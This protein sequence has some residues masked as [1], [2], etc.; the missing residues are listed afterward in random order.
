MAQRRA[1][2]H[3]QSTRVV[4]GTI[5]SFSPHTGCG[6]AVCDA[7]RLRGRVERESIA[8][9]ASGFRR[10]DGTPGQYLLT[11]VKEAC[12]L[13]GGYAGR[14]IV[15]RVWRGESGLRARSWGL[16]PHRTIHTDIIDI[17]GLEQYVGGEC[18]AFH[19]RG[20]RPGDYVT[21]K[22]QSVTIEGPRITVEILDAHEAVGLG[23]KRVPGG[24]A[25]ICFDLRSAKVTADATGGC[26]I[27]SH[28]FVDDR[29]MT[30]TF[31]LPRVR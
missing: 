27:V 10:V 22:L 5:R 8:F 4:V 31:R 15:M 3:G 17:G 14:R 16:M 26:I 12:T 2:A 24:Y 11:E 21:G 29:R 28:H 30:L 23:T 18:D 7:Y 13:D 19:V 9:Y 6:F 1:K 25:C 20:D